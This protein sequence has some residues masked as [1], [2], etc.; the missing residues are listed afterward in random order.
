M[1]GAVVLTTGERPAELARAIASLRRQQQVARVVIVVNA[2]VDVS[3][4]QGRSGDPHDYCASPSRELARRI[5]VDAATD[6]IVVTPGRNLGIPGGRNFGVEQL[7]RASSATADESASVDAGS[8][9]TADGA[10]DGDVGDVHSVPEAIFFLD[11]DARLA[12]DDIA[13][14]VAQAFD[15]DPQLAIVTMRVQDPDT[16]RTERRHVPRLRVGDPSRSSWVTTFLGGACVIR[17]AAYIG[18]G[19]LPDEFFYAHE[20]TSLAWRVIDAGGKIRYR[21]D[22]V[23]EHPAAAPSRH[24][25]AYRLSA[26]NRVLLAHL[27]LPFVVGMFYVSIWTVLSAVRAPRAL[28]QV[29]RGLREGLAMRHLP[30]QPIR[31]RTVL[32]LTRYGRPPII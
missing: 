16:G 4:T 5:G 3:D 19:G 27:H 21:G 14:C 12:S 28:G 32:T 26:R 31:W 20:E 1:L 15:Q 8:T 18:A 23:V 7:I 24:T 2:D 30:R 25:D 22:L 10:H 13:A 29:L 17:T 9:S 11:D 6:L